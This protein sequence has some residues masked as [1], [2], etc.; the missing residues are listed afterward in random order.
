MTASTAAA[1]PASNVPTAADRDNPIDL[2]VTVDYTYES[3]QAEIRREDAGQPLAP[4]TRTA[5][6]EFKQFRHLLTPRADL[7]IYKDTWFSFALTIT[8]TQTREHDLA[9]GVMRETST[10]LQDG[11]LP[12]GGFDANDPGTPLVGNAIFRGKSRKGLSQAHIGLNVAPMNQRRDPTKPTWKLGGELRLAVGK[13][14]KFDEARLGDETGVSKGVHELRLWTSVAREFRRNEGWFE[15]FWQV[16]LQAREGSLFDDP[17]FGSTNVNLGQKAGVRFGLETYLV[18]DTVNR[19]RIS[20]DLGAGVTAH[21]EGRDYTEMWE[22]FAFAGDASTTRPLVLDQDPTEDGVQP[23]SHPGISNHEN[24]LETTAK[25]AMRAKIS[26]VA[27][28]AVSI[29]LDWRTDHTITFADA[30][31]DLPLCGTTTGLCEDLDNDLVNPNT[32]EV[33]PLHAPRIDLVG[34][35]YHSTDSFSFIVGVHGMVLF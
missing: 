23:L 30:G 5:D 16:P 26:T 7:A 12:M 19:N 17:G 11:L 13:V 2:H 31:I 15:L 25:I 24:Y 8:L 4:T 18:D 32:R 33:N 6:L 14:M 1:N 10:T 22:I 3:E 20:L 27:Q 28:F 21:F 29:D 34:H 9:D 35:R